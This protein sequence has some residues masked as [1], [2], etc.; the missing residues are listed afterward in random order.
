[1]QM[2]SRWTDPKPCTPGVTVRV[3]SELQ[4]DSDWHINLKLVFKSSWTNL[5]RGRLSGD[6][7]IAD[8]PPAVPGPGGPQ[9]TTSSQATQLFSKWRSTTQWVKLVCAA[10]AYRRV[11]AIR[12]QWRWSWWIYMTPYRGWGENSSTPG[13]NLQKSALVVWASITKIS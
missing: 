9:A 5:N 10:G 2:V 1:M 6:I 7:Q 13:I 12:S 11:K 3:L 8:V 4:Q